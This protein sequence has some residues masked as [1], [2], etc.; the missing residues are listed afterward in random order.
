VAEPA[1]ASARLDRYYTL[2]DRFAAQLREYDRAEYVAIKT[3][4]FT[5]QRERDRGRGD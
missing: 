1:R 2:T 3:R 5:E 4:E